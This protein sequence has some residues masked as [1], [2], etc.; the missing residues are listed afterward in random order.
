MTMS[1][2]ANVGPNHFLFLGVDFGDRIWGSVWRTPV[3]YSKP[4]ND[5]FGYMS[6]CKKKRA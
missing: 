1:A 4:Y 6:F 5:R 3:C 2:M